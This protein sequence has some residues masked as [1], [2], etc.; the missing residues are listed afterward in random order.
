MQVEHEADLLLKGLAVTLGLYHALIFICVFLVFFLKHSYIKHDIKKAIAALKN[1]VLSP[2]IQIYLGIWLLSEFFSK[3]IILLIYIALLILIAAFYF[4]KGLI[5]MA[6]HF[7]DIWRADSAVFSLLILIVIYATSLVAILLAFATALHL[8][9]TERW[10]IKI[11][12][13]SKDFLWRS[14]NSK[15]IAYTRPII[16]G[17]LDILE[18][19]SRRCRM[20]VTIFIAVMSFVLHLLLIVFGVSTFEQ[21]SQIYGIYIFATIVWFFYGSSIYSHLLELFNFTTSD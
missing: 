3:V 15:G 20:W 10:N 19:Y 5:G 7:P 16:E 13:Y 4:V 1:M 6:I 21:L 12:K 8:N 18:L 11:N 2:F 14:T 9:F 17:K